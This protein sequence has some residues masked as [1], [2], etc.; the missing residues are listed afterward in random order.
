[1]ITGLV[2]IANGGRSRM[3]QSVI[4]HES[5]RTTKLYDRTKKRLTYDEVDAS[6]VKSFCISASNHS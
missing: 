3:Q 1:M 6:D 5:L 2:I 4:A